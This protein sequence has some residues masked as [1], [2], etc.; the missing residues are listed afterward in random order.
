MRTSSSSLPLRVEQG[1]QS[2]VSD[3]QIAVVGPL[4]EHVSWVQYGAVLLC[5]S[6]AL[7]KLMLR[8]QATGEVER[9]WAPALEPPHKS[10]G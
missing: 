10:I 4:T 7:A 6:Q 5:A 2:E 3:S 9:V 1:R 8:L